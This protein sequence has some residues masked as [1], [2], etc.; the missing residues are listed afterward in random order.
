M[1]ELPNLEVAFSLFDWLCG[2]SPAAQLACCPLICSREHGRDDGRAHDNG[3]GSRGKERE[4]E[5]GREERG[6]EGGRS[7]KH[8]EGGREERGEGG[9][10]KEGGGRG[11]EGGGRGKER[12]EGGREERGG[13]GTEREEKER[14]REYEGG[15]EERKRS[16]SPSGRDKEKERERSERARHEERCGD[17]GLLGTCVAHEERCGDTGLPGPLLRMRPLEGG[18]PDLTSNIIN[19]GRW[20]P[21]KL[22]SNTIMPINLILRVMIS[23]LWPLSFGLPPPR[24]IASSDD[25]SSPSY[26]LMRCCAPPPSFIAGARTGP[27]ASGTGTMIA[28]GPPAD[29]ADHDVEEEEDRHTL[30]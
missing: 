26:I 20:A 6:E 1:D 10:G 15:R 8:E 18:G 24:G 13:R 23:W 22:K 30:W 29:A 28:S 5:G 16:R 14:E 25:M 2:D 17:A 3:K 12:E 7:K 19:L 21:A 27:A 9:R 4:H 11:K